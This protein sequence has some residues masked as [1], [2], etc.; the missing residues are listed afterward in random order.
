MAGLSAWC[1]RRP[2][3]AAVWALVLLA[4]GS[5]ARAFLPGRV[6]SPADALFTAFPWKALRPGSVAAN[7]V[8]TDVTFQIHPRLLHVASE[9]SRGHFP[10]WSPDIFTGAPLFAN[11]NSAILFPLNALAYVLPI[12]LALALAAV[13]KLLTAGLGMH[14][15]LRL[16]GV[17]PLGAFMGAAA[18]MLN[19]ALVVWLQN[20]VGG[21]IALLPLLL[22]LGEWLRQRPGAGPVVALACAV[23][24]EVFAGYPPIA[25]LGALAA[26]LWAL[27]RAR[28]APGGPRF[29]LRW[30]A[31]MGLGAALA[32]V[33]LLPFLEYM[34]ESAIYAYRLEWKPVLALPPRAAI[35]FLMPHYY[36]GPG[37]YWGPWNFNEITTSVGLL[38]WVALPAA[39]VGAWRRPGT[40]FFVA[41]GALAATVLYGVPV[42][43]PGLATL[44]LVSLAIS[45]RVA[46]LLVL[47]LCALGGIG[48]DTIVSAARGSRRALRCAVAAGLVAL[49]LLALAS[50]VDDYATAVRAGMGV[51]L[52]LQYLAF[53][54]LSTGLAL[55]LLR[56][57]CGGLAGS[58]W[59]LAL[60]L[61]QLASTLP[62]A[63][64][65]NPVMEERWLYPSTPAIEH[66]KRE[67]ARDPGRVLLQANLAMLYGLSDPSGYDGMTPRRL[68][69]LVRPGGGLTLLGNGSLTVADVWASPVVDLLGVRRVLV[70]PGIAVAGPGY[71]LEYD[72]ADARVYRNDRALPRAFLVPSARCVDDATALTLIAAREVD[73]RQ[74]VL[75]GGC[76]RVP[77]PGL[78]GHRRRALIRRDEPSRVTIDTTADAPAYL[79]L[80]DTWFPGWRASVD[81]VAEPVLRAN[82]ALRAVRLGPGTHEVVFQYRPGSVMLGLGVSLAAGA[83]A[84]GLAVASRRR[85]RRQAEPEGQPGPRRSRGDWAALG[86][87]VAALVAG[88][89]LLRS[90][91]PAL[92]RAP[93]DFTLSPSTVREGA[94]AVIRVQHRGE[95]SR[96]ERRPVDLYIASLLGWEGAEFLTPEGAW[97][98]RPVPFRRAQSLSGLAPIEAPWPWERKVGSLRL[99]LIVVDATAD[100]RRRSSW[101][102]Q[103]ALVAVDLKASITG[104]LGRA[105]A[106]AVLAMLGLVTLGA[107]LLVLRCSQAR[108]PLADPACD[109]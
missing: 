97:S 84:V 31:A 44:P 75:L 92:P 22:A 39:L 59:A 24:L 85:P 106:V 82:H 78:P 21:A 4:L 96:E 19:G 102:F 89:A 15:L 6:L 64:G 81:G 100:P 74:E 28:G 1:R 69:R 66:L 93:L 107:V 79:V 23:A 14:W 25:L 57:L 34:R 46:P 65:Y 91:G 33:Q 67:S 56:A 32:A 90:P 8:L 41:L 109:A 55:L 16:L 87:L 9:I 26:G 30:A 62:L 72:G 37:D 7:P 53:L 10:L 103:P 48:V 95:R 3:A 80:T 38:P 2:D 68:E 105:R 52:A 29:L 20:T 71:A 76:E 101:L 51:P 60:V 36:G 42:L 94:P 54:A 47:A 18:F 43:A 70:P 98:D 13:L 35:V 104:D 61:L 27:A 50:V 17:G 83:A 108:A 49:A 86:L 12:G 40:G 11:P 99:A 58:R 45:L 88:G 5:Q 73:F 77:E 63:M